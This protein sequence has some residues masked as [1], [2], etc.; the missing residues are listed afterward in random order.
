MNVHSEIVGIHYFSNV[1]QLFQIVKFH[2]LK[3]FIVVYYLSLQNNDFFTTLH[4]ESSSIDYRIYERND[5]S[6]IQQSSANLVN[7]SFMKNREKSLKNRENSYS[8]G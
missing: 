1:Y 7:Y 4:L 3:K 2:Y 8:S 6:K 5:Q